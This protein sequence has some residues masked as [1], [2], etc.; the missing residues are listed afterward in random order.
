MNFHSTKRNG[1]K[2]YKNDS[3][4]E[5]NFGVYCFCNSFA[6]V[7]NYRRGQI[8]VDST[9]VIMVQFQNQQELY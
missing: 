9:V 1:Q 4:E 5:K 6:F 8:M 7:F 3:I 2:F